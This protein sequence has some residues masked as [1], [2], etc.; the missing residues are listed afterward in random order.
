MSTVS[1]MGEVTLSTMIVTII[2]LTKSVIFTMTV[3]RLPK[4]STSTP[5]SKAPTISPKPRPVMI[6]RD[7]WFFF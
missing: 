4:R 5:I 2:E 6:K 1:G 7:T 3:F